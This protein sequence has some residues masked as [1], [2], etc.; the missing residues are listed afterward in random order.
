[1]R[2]GKTPIPRQTKTPCLSAGPPNKQKKP[3][4]FGLVASDSMRKK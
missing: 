3:L 4:F 1:M 2:C